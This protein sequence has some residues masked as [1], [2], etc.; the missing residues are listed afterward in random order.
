MIAPNVLT[1]VSRFKPEMTLLLPTIDD[2]KSMSVVPLN[3]E[4]GLL[5]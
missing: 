3:L 4:L 2:Y 5:A 1:P